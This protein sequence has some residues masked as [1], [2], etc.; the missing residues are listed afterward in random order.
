MTIE[1]LFKMA[2][3]PLPTTDTGITVDRGIYYPSLGKLFVLTFT[4]F[5]E[6]AEDNILYSLSGYGNTLEEALL[7]LLKQ[8]SGKVLV[9]RSNLRVKYPLI[10]ILDDKKKGA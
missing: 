5:P 9:G 3:G 1:E 2:S 4:E 8:A 10:L 7:D 6:Y